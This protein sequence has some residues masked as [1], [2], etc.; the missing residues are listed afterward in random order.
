MSRFKKI[1]SNVKSVKP[2]HE[3]IFKNKSET[4]TIKC[5]NCGAPR[6]TNTN[7]TIC[8]YCGFKFMDIDAEI[9]EDK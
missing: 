3:K 1:I 4:E 5:K 8:D 6:N 2:E 9:R 7:L